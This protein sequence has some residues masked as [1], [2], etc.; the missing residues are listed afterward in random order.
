MSP[1]PPRNGTSRRSRSRR[2]SSK[3]A[4]AV[5][6]DWE[7]RSSSPLATRCVDPPPDKKSSH[8]EVRRNREKTDHVSKD[9]GRD[10]A[11]A[12]DRSV[13]QSS[14]RDDSKAVEKVVE[15]EEVRRNHDVTTSAPR[16]DDRLAKE[17]PE[18]ERS[19]RIAERAASLLRRKNKEREAKRER[20]EAEGT[21]LDP[22]LR[23]R[24]TSTRTEEEGAADLSSQ[25]DDGRRRKDRHE[26]E[27]A[28]RH[29]ERRTQREP[30]RSPYAA[31]IDRREARKSLSGRE[32]EK[33]HDDR[34][35]QGKRRFRESG[36]DRRRR[37]ERQVSRSIP[38]RKASR[39][40]SAASKDEGA[41]DLAKQLEDAK[42]RNSKIAAREAAG[43][44]DKPP[45]AP[46]GGTQESSSGTTPAI[47]PVGPQ[48][49][50]TLRGLLDRSSVL[51]ADAQQ[52]KQQVEEKNAKLA[53]E[54]EEKKEETL[55]LA[56]PLHDSLLDEDNK[57]RLLALTGLV[58]VSLTQEKDVVVRANS[59]RE[60]QIA[61]GKLRRLAYHCQWGCSK[62]K[63]GELLL[64]RPLKP[65]N[66]MVLRLAA[67]SSRLPS[68]EARLTGT[69]PKLRVGTT[70]GMCDLLIQSVSGLSRKHCTITFEPEK[71]AAY[72]QDLSTNGTFLNGKRLPKPPYKSIQDARVRLV[73]GDEVS[74]RRK[75][76]ELEE[77]GWMVNI[78]KLG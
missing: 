5:Q 3:H 38:A 57:P 8:K 7:D 73:H 9:D 48:M 70:N 12:A 61:I 51:A 10:T 78:V 64:G 17:L 76:D 19:K 32:K 23:R 43:Q 41:P 56:K 63:V 74:I 26:I 66:S 54:K 46:E 31:L 25:R 13:R 75:S 69:S 59:Q 62:E 28:S 24:K 49:S 33:E 36:D 35:G 37:E 72:I 50:E 15:R 4:E 55:R 52:L 6:E 1:N 27:N 14:R 71:G 21:S 30:S 11:K 18:T 68:H 40:L 42:I 47:A 65:L 44:F 16:S 20:D 77:L 45:P 2:R 29:R 22:P 34:G 60:L 67:V 53:A 58:G 39:S